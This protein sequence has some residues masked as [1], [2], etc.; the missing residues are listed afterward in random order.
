ME[1]FIVVR[2]DEH[3]QPGRSVTIRNPRVFSWK[4]FKA[5]RD[6][7]NASEDGGLDV[8]RDLISSWDVLDE[9][10]DPLPPL[11]E[12]PDAVED[13]PIEVLLA[14]METAFRQLDGLSTGPKAPGTPSATT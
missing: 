7:A 8:L 14:V 2:L 9:Q 1:T 11:S 3:G 5:L 10:G 6:K 12:R 13:V 4:R